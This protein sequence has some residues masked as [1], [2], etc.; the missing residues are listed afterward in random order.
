[1]IM[2]GRI[3]KPVIVVEQNLHRNRSHEPL[4]HLWHEIIVALASL[5]CQRVALTSAYTV[6]QN[7]RQNTKYNDFVINIGIFM[8]ILFANLY[9]YRKLNG[10]LFKQT[11]TKI[12]LAKIIKKFIRPLLC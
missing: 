7:I 12:L 11:N 9:F 3:C 6:M 2:A 5:S 10:N 4:Y 1:M 8:M